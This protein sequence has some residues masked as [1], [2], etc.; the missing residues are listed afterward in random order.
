MLSPNEALEPA[1]VVYRAGN[2]W[3][4]K[5]Y[6]WDEVVEDD[7]REPR[8]A[9]LLWSLIE[10]LGLEGSRYDAR[11]IYVGLRPGDKHHDYHPGPCSECECKCDP[12]QSTPE[13]QP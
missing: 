8:G 12:D 9:G 2:G 10:A 7:P 1:L 4:V 6:E 13:E 3:L 5:G 11:R